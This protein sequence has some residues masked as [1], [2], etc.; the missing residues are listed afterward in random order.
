[1]HGLRRSPRQWSLA[2]LAGPDFFLGSLSSVI[3]AP[4]DCLMIVNPRPLLGVWPL[5][6]GSQHPVPTC[7]GEHADICP[8]L[9]SAGWL[10][11]LCRIFCILSS[12]HLLCI[13]LWGCK[14][15]IVPT[16]EGV[17]ECVETC[18]FT[19]PSPRHRSCPESFVFFSF[20]FCFVLFHVFCPVDLLWDFHVQMHFLCICGEKG[21]LCILL[22]C[23]LDGPPPYI[24]FKNILWMAAYYFFTRRY[25]RVGHLYC[26]RW[27]TITNT[28]LMYF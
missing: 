26:C 17:S 28:I 1:M 12:T 24:F 14:V 16:C 22:P 9:G 6:P 21:D 7:S 18:S 19:I 23:H 10:W 2:S 8:R 3:L 20:L 5:K 13:L 15:P 27:F 4:S 25:G 11:S